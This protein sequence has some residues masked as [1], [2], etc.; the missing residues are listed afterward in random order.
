MATF[1]ALW[2]TPADVEAFD[3][4][5]RSVHMPTV[6]DWPGVQSTSVTRVSGTPRGTAA[7]YHVVTVVSFASVEDLQTALRSDAGMA[8]AKDAMGMT[9]QFG[10]ELTMLLGDDFA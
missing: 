3:E 2:S 6:A 7:P 1:T 5:Y 4:Y 8:T 10:V 9:K